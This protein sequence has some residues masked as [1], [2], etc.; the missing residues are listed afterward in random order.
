MESMGKMLRSV[1]TGL[2]RVCWALASWSIGAGVITSF[3]VLSTQLVSRLN[4]GQWSSYP[5]TLAAMDLGVRIPRAKWRPV[6]DIIDYVSVS[7]IYL[8]MTEAE[9]LIA[10]VLYGMAMLIN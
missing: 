8:F 7:D 5:V 1:R 6:Q 9:F 4:L 3:A 2:A 10:A